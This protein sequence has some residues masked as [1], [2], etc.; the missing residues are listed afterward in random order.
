MKRLIR[1]VV[2][3]LCSALALSCRIQESE[4][5]PELSEDIKLR[6]TSIEA[7]QC[8]YVVPERTHVIDGAVLQ[9]KPGDRICLSASNTYKNLLFKNIVGTT[10]LPVIIT[11]CGGTALLNATGLSFGLKTQ[12]SKHFRITGGSSAYVYGIKVEGGH[13]GIALG[14]LSTNFEVDHVEVANSG[15]AGIMAKTDPSCD[16]ATSRENFTMKNINLNYNYVHDCGGEGFYV[17]NSF[18]EAG[19]KTECG[20]R[21]PHEIHYLRLF[22]N[23]VKNTG[24]DGIQ[25]GCATVGTKI[26]GNVIE[27]YGT[28]NTYNQRNGMQLGEGTGGLCYGNFINGGAGNGMNVLGIGTNVIHNNVIVDAGEMGIFCD[29]RYTPGPGFTFLNNTI[30]NPAIDGIRLYAEKVVMNHV[31][32]NIIVNPGNFAKYVY[33]RVADDAFVYKLSKDLPVEIR[34]N[35]FTTSIVDV[36]FVDPTAHN[37]RL[38][39]TSPIIDKGADIS[40]YAIGTDFYK[41]SRLRGA[42]YD[43]GAAEVQ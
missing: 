27:N 39:L 36:G 8:T 34:N 23:I 30:V 12:N 21:Y 3:L 28:S 26:Y 13:I 43:I 29:D 16:P 37:F 15:F 9:I 40:S 38:T 42:A 24:W 35:F 6:A 19:V 32:N 25:V 18:F 7:C 22:S 14:D 17:G 2:C 31:I 5:D 10:E 20:T 11:N 1:F 4:I 41:K 33:P